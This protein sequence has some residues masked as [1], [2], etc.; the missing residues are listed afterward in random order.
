ML[1]TFVFLCVFVCKGGAGL[2]CE[3]ER[4]CCPADVESALRQSAASDFH[5]AVRQSSHQLRHT[6]TQ[7]STAIQ[8]TFFFFKL[9]LFI[10][11]SSISFFGHSCLTFP[12]RKNGGKKKKKKK[13]FVFS[14]YVS[15]NC[16]HDVAREKKRGSA[17][18]G[19]ATTTSD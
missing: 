6:L 11:L 18:F 3:G 15:R 2:I 1:I 7:S 5:H 16:E 10:Y 4:T 19:I 14:G 17:I 12:E 9:K 8:G 13:R